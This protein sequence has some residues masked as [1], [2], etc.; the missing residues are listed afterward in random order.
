MPTRSLLSKAVKHDSVD[1]H[2]SLLAGFRSPRCPMPPLLEVKRDLVRPREVAQLARPLRGH[3]PRATSALATGN[4]PVNL[5][6]TIDQAGE[7]NRLNKWLAREESN[8]RRH[9]E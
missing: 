6:G 3:G 7:V 5:A 1:L 8:T 2:R 4:N 9:L